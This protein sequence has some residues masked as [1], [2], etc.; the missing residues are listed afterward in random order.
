MKTSLRAFLLISILV[1]TLTSAQ[2]QAADLALSI[3]R[4]A[5]WPLPANEHVSVS[6]GAIIRVVDQG[7]AVKI[8]AL[9][10]GTAVIKTKTT[11]LEVLVLPEASYRFYASL[12]SAIENRR[13]LK[14]SAAR[15]KLEVRGR[16]LRAEDW[17]VIGESL[18]EAKS[19]SFSFR[20][21]VED[22][23][24]LEVEKNL[25]R[26][27][28]DVGV[29]Q[30]NLRFTPEAVATVGLEPK[31]AKERV[32]KILSPYG[33]RVEANSSVLT[34]EPLVRVKILV[35]E[36]SKTFSR[37]LGLKLPTSLSGQLLPKLA[38]DPA[39]SLFSIEAAEASGDLRVL[40]SPTLLCRSG[41][42]AE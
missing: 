15:G 32:E 30:V 39:S 4:T 18:Q 37:N 13:G 24:R 5:S 19:G 9:K 25:L 35:A 33:F 22:E 34:L 20:A 10:L 11:E 14:I 12:S 17:E 28:R 8:T 42:E 7:K 31:D 16:L 29:P 6:N 41:K 40:A 21:E 26:K 36:V 38:F 27:L 2:S 23:V 1:I 3:G